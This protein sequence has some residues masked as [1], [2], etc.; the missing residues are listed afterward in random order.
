FGRIKRLA[1]RIVL[2]DDLE[3]RFL[4]VLH[5]PNLTLAVRADAAAAD[6]KRAPF[7]TARIDHR[8]VPFAAIGTFHVPTAPKPF[9]ER[10]YSSRAANALPI[11]GWQRAEQAA[12]LGFKSTCASAGADGRKIAQKVKDFANL[13]GDAVSMWRAKSGPYSTSNSSWATGLTRIPSAPSRTGPSPGARQ[14]SIARC[15]VSR[16]RTSGRPRSCC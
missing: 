15:P 2:F 7:L 11:T 1:P 13:G 14:C 5:G 8:E 4:D 16:G 9:L 10:G 3:R 6:G 12:T